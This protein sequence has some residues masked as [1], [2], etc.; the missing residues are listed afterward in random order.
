MSAADHEHPFLI[1][2]EG[3][4][5]L[6]YG[7]L[8]ERLRDADYRPMLRPAST[9]E[10]LIG[11]LQAL[12]R[13][14]P[15]RL[16]DGDFSPAELAALG[17]EPSTLE[18]RE[19]LPGQGPADWASAS[20]C[21]AATTGFSL[22]LYTSGST[23]LPKLVRHRLPTL[24]RTLKTGERHRDSVWALAYNP[25]HIAGIQVLLQA[26][27]NRNTLVDVFKLPRA[28]IWQRLE[29][30]GVT[31]LSATPTFYRLLLPAENPLPRVRSLTL[32]GERS[33]PTLLERLGAAFP[34][35]RLHNLY[36]STEAGTLLM[37]E[38]EVFGIH[39]AVEGRV[40][41]DAGQLWV[42]RE[43]LADFAGSRSAADWY[44]TGDRVEITSEAPLRFRILGRETDWVNVGGAKVSPAE[45]EE[46]LL[47]HPDVRE[48]RVYGRANSV[49]GT[50][51]CAE[52][53]SESPLDETVLRAHLA[54]RLQPHKVPR[55]LKRVATLA[56]TRS[57][58]L[59]RS[60]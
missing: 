36:A 34:S 50:L 12:V 9:A 18:H 7:Q 38:G 20:S 43:L 10:A 25:T 35:A 46:A 19:P 52:I 37:A 21:A 47:S 33:D 3:T 13:G 40:K 53:V 22:E 57:G 31:H 4:V 1:S 16:V 42:A 32:G 51:L 27:F 23:G 54:A 49:V 48:C 56:V 15:L 8:C 45:V 2:P 11:V 6:T 5:A 55:V 59:A 39:P 41:V 58:K 14:A 24:T 26:F 60:V 28:E 30:C 44:P 17:I 29:T